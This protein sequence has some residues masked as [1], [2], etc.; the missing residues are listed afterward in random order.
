MQFRQVTISAALVALSW[1]ALSSAHQHGPRLGVRSGAGI[2]LNSLNGRQTVVYTTDGTCGNDYAGAGKGM[3]CPKEGGNL[4]C[5][6]KGYCGDKDEHCGICQPAFGK[7][8]EGDSTTARVTV[9]GPTHNNAK[10]INGE[11]CSSVGYCGT[12]TAH[13][14]SPDCLIN[15]GTCDA[16]Q[17]PDGENTASVDR[18]PIGNVSYTTDIHSCTRAGNVALTFDD[19]P[20]KYTP[21]ILDLLTEYDMKATFFVTGVNLGKG[22]IDDPTYGWDTMIKRMIADGHQIASH[23]WSHADLTKIT[24][25]QRKDEIIKLEMA[26]RNILGDGYI[27]T[28]MRPPYSSCTEECRS[29]LNDLGYHITYFDLDTDDY[30]RGTLETISG[31]KLIFTNKVSTV[32]PA[33]S[34]FLVIAHDIQEMTVTQLT[35]HMLQTIKDAG[36]K[37]VTVGQCL[38]DPEENWYRS[39]GGDAVTNYTA[40]ASASAGSEKSVNTAAASAKGSAKGS[41]SAVTV[42][43]VGFTMSVGMALGLG[44]WAVI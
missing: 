2:D 25:E 38:D 40:E 19:G 3:H 6:Y 36:F 16:S 12:T 5:S 9:C 20:Y 4:C 22:A 21:E 32:D 29:D 41:G 43:A 42:S 33:N 30:N 11:C 34:K 14:K 8:H 1:T 44:F 13:C 26:L 24:K 10:C 7:C 15:F 39:G 23:T 35:K 17:T 27:P 31:S 37:G 28:Y 18:S